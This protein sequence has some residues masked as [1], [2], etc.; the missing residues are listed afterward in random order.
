MTADRLM[1]DKKYNNSIYGDSFSMRRRHTNRDYAEHYHNCC[2]IE[3]VLSGEGENSDNGERYRYTTG[4]ICFLT[5]YDSHGHY[6]GTETELYNIMLDEKHISESVYKRLVVRRSF[7]KANRV[8]FSE[9]RFEAVKKLFEAMESEYL[10]AVKRGTNELCDRTL[11]A[12][13]DAV[14]L[15]LLNELE[16][17]D[18]FKD[19]SEPRISRALMYIYVHQR[20]SLTLG[21]AAASVHLSPGYFSELFSE[22]VGQNFKSY[23]TDLRMRNACRLLANTDMSVTDIC[24][25]CGFESFSNFMRTFKTRY[26]LSPLKFR[27]SH[28]SEEMQ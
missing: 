24:Y 1:L 11:E 5:P 4:D 17:G 2:E 14:L 22:T 26:G 7:G 8:R 15:M 9:K 3:L 21:D 27:T 19:V 16:S 12:M 18:G 6:P 13:V 23:L 25:E 20:E 28:K 10:E